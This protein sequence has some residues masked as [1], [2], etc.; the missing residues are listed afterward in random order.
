MTP[1]KPPKAPPFCPNPKCPFHTGDTTSWRY[2]RN[3][4]YQSRPVRPSTT[5]YARSTRRY[6]CREC[7]R[8]FSDRTFRST[9]RLK[10]PDIFL[11]VARG[12]VSCSGYRQ[13]ATGLNVSPQ[14]VAR[15]AARLGKQSLLFHEE[16]RKS[17]APAEPLALDSFVS[18]A[19]SQYFPLHFHI[20][21]GRTSHF[22]YGFSESEVRRSGTM[23]PAQRARREH[24]E[25]ELGRPD[26][27]AR[28]KDVAVLLKIVANSATLLDLTTDEDQ[29]YPRAIRRSQLAVQHATISSKA[30]RTTSNPLFASNLHDLQVRHAGANHKR[31]TIAFSKTIRGAV[32]RM[33]LHLV[34]KNYVK[35]FSE[36]TQGATPAQRVGI[37]DR[38]WSFRHIFRNRRFPGRVGL[39]ERWEAHFKGT[40]VTR[41]FGATGQIFPTYAY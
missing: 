26:P 14:T 19:Y 6:I 1:W 28:E 18:F 31:E 33:W 7:K 24:L 41:A 23:T 20:V 25:K 30:R 10:R 16:M 8:S 13:L 21:M 9:Y 5:V 39:P 4:T 2:V 38:K 27:K 12:L 29:A 36:K 35:S 34:W 32:E 3:G 37:T 11:K 40:V 17:L 15:H 22:A